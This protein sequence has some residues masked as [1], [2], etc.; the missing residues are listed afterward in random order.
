MNIQLKNITFEYLDHTKVFDEISLDLDVKK[1]QTNK[2][3]G[4]IGPSGTGKTTLISIIGGQLN[5]QSGEVLINGQNIY[6]LPDIKK[7]DLLAVQLQNST[8]IRGSVKKNLTFGISLLEHTDE[9]KAEYEKLT[10]DEFLVKLLKSV[11]LW[12]IFE[13]KDGLNTKIG[14]GGIN[15]SGGQRQR[16][17]FASLYLRSLYF[18]PSVVLIDEP[19]SSLDEI[20]EKAITKMIAEISQKSLTLVVAHRLNTLSSAHAL[21]DTSI[22]KENSEIGVYSRSELEKLRNII[23]NL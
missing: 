19:T 20:S 10:N 15:L 21:I 12:Q 2:L 4:I 5:P 11:G 13:K 17:N 23:K 18:N 14:E 9:K 16:L 8:A 22:L 3:I 7:R 6:K 1:N